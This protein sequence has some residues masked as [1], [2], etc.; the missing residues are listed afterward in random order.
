MMTDREWQEGVSLALHDVARRGASL[1]ERE[2]GMVEVA[3]EWVGAVSA[4]Y[5][6]RERDGRL[7]RSVATGLF[8]PLSPIADAVLGK[9]S[10]RAQLLE[11]VLRRS[12]QLTAESLAAQI[13]VSG[14]GELFADVAGDVRF[15]GHPDPALTVRS[16]I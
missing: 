10:T 2:Q 4:A 8:P 6:E 15:V 1:V 16:I 13:A 14:R 11:H 7:R 3:T 5:Y 9:F 12:E